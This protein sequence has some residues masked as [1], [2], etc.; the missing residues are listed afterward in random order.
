[1]CEVNVPI[2]LRMGVSIV[3]SLRDSLDFINDKVS[4]DYV[5]KIK[6]SAQRHLN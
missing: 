3:V 1:M 5:T 2:A 6:S 4:F